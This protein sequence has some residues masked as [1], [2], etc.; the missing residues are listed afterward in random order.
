VLMLAVYLPSLPTFWF[1]E[2]WTVVDTEDGE[3]LAMPSTTMLYV[4][5]GTL[6]ENEPTWLETLPSMDKP[7]PIILPE[8][9]SVSTGLTVM[10]MLF[11]PGICRPFMLDL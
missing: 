2:A 7:I 8:T 6:L 9:V 11:P 4:P 3:P 1:W 10:L 5:D